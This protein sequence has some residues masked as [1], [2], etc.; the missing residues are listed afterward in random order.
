[1]ISRNA[2]RDT[3]FICKGAAFL[4]EY[5]E[6]AA[7]KG[8]MAY[9]SEKPVLVREEL[10]GLIVTDIR[11]PWRWFPL[12]FF[13]YEPGEGEADGHYGNQ[14]KDPTTAW[15]LKAMLDAW[16]KSHGRPETGTDFHRGKL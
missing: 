6:E 10:P 14:G 8:S 11:K 3:L 2:V 13:G 4:P 7:E 9:I 16:E 1:M 12:C 15:Y 5:L